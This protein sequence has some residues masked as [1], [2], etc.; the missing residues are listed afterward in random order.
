MTREEALE[1]GMSLG[2]NP[3]TYGEQCIMVDTILVMYTASCK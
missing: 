2:L 3:T 1:Y